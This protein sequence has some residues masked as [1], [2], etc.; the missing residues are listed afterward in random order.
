MNSQIISVLLSF[1][2]PT[3]T[4]EVGHISQ[5]PV[6]KRSDPFLQDLVDQAIALSQIDS[7]ESET[8][9]DF[10]APPWS[11]SLEAT[12]WALSDRQAQLAE[13][14]RQIDEEVYRLYDISDEDRSAI[15]AELGNGALPSAAE[16]ESEPGD[17]EESS[18][19]LSAQ[20]LAHRWIS[21]AVG[22][23]LGRF[24]PG[25][26]GALGRGN[27]SPETAEQLRAL[28]DA[29]GIAALEAG[30]P[31]DLAGKVEGI[32]EIAL[33][34]EGTHQVLTA[35]LGKGAGQEGLRQYLARDFWKLHIQQYRKRPVYWLLQ[36]PKKSA[37]Y[38]LFHERVNR[39]T[40][41]L[42]RGSKYLGG[43][44]HLLR[45][46]LQELATA[47]N[48][49]E[50]REKRRLEKAAESQ[51]EELADLEAFDR[52]LAKVL[53]TT[54]ERGQ[55]VG[56]APQIDDGV[57]LNLAPLFELLPS[58]RAEPKKFWEEL[59][60]GK[61]DWSHTAMRYWPDRVLSKCQVNRSYA[62]AHDVKLDETGNG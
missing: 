1:L 52:N 21:Y 54:D 58:W 43:R 29:D 15:K 57:I 14:E 41:P 39:D 60:A 35:V 42:L 37:A 3:I 31:D 5:L 11:G 49:L 33:G 25:V 17:E 2:S 56:W 26:E 34:E 12:L 27:F 8:T 20:E 48:G 45:M 16:E 9:F 36:S 18:A 24:Q 10:L 38:L 19:S 23:A 4:Y 47:V 6:P 51:E 61:Y 50:E 32:L 13:T 53:E 28:A 62:I 7:A 30:H 44:I 22:I 46:R 55:T 59:V 40:L